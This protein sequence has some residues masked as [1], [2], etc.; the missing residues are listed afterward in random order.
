V[1]NGASVVAGV[2]LAQALVHLL[3]G[4]RAAALALTGAVCTSLADLPLRPERN[5][6]RVGAAAVL[7]L[8]ATTLVLLLKPHP[9]VL[10]LGIAALTFVAMMTLG[11][12]PR[13]GPISFAAVLALVFT[14]GLPPGDSLHEVLAAQA[15]GA[16][17]YGVWAWASSLLLQPVYRRRALSVATEAT[18]RL[19][20]ARMA[21]L[22]A[23]AGDETPLRV[24]IGAEAQLAERLQAARDLLFAAPRS[25]QVE[26]QTAQLLRLI[27]LRDLLLAG[28]LDFERFGTDALGQQLRSAS[29]ARLGRLAEVLQQAPPTLPPLHEP[30]LPAAAAFGPGDARRALLPAIERRLQRLAGEVERVHALQQGGSETPLLSPAELQQ[31]VAPEGWPLQALRPHFTLA[32]PVLRHALR[33]GA[34][35]GAAFYIA[36][37]LPWASHPQWLV[38]SVAVVLRS[39]FDQTVSRRN[40]RVAGTVL[41]CL[42]VLALSHVPRPLALSVVFVAAIGLAHGFA[43]ERYLVTAMAGTVMALLQAHLVAP[44]GGFPIAERVADTVLGAALAWAFSY[45]LPSW[46]K[47]LL[48][49]TIG[50]LREALR[51]YARSVLINTPAVPQRLERRRAYDAL[52]ALTA[53]VQRSAAEPAAVRPPLAPLGALIDQSQRL[54]AHLSMLRLLLQRE[55]SALADGLR[56]EIARD[57]DAALAAPGTSAVP[58]ELPEPPEPPANPDGSLQPWLR[59]RLALTQH[60]ALAVQQAAQ[61]AQKT[62]RPPRSR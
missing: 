9:A 48:P 34:A 11:W 40:L 17:L 20:R 1:I 8:A 53:S 28:S 51:D 57:I 27:D 3:L 26:R 38:L 39:S 4:P 24:W 19:L 37:A 52:G 60:A 49:R 35:L 62:L 13:A 23:A 25:S 12:G 47:R 32:S 21:V 55:Q 7:A 46:E 22:Q 33:A 31:F 54:M 44:A 42:V 5:W 59:W 61:A 43:V 29:L 58:G 56:Q 15:A 45:V 30:A 41:G 14:M 50:R 16:L 36:L 18:G 6:R 10:G 2:L